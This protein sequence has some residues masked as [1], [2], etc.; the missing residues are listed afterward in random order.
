MKK[1]LK[2]IS[3]VAAIS[4]VLAYLLFHGYF[5]HGKFEIRQ[6]QWSSSK[7]VA[8]LAE[9]SDKEALGGLT[10]FVLIGDHVFSPDEL[11]HAYHSD[12]PIFAAMATC[13]NLQ[14]K[15]TR[16][17]VV[18]C[19]GSN[20]DQEYIDVEKKQSAGVS[21]SYVNISPNTAQTFHPK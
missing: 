17:L 8:M 13:L 2:A 15:S 5:D 6:V 11:R 10:F 14:W 4:T 12:A 1:A 16:V 21:I 20:L 18:A 19:D 9:R 7:Q 3:A